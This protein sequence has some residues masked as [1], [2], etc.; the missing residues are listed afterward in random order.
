[1]EDGLQDIRPHV[2][3]FL[4]L[5]ATVCDDSEEDLEELSEDGL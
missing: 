3:R 5:S 2:M 1:M 4:D